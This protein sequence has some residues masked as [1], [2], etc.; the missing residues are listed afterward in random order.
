MQNIEN[1]GRFMDAESVEKYNKERM[2]AA[3]EKA[4]LDQEANPTTEELLKKIL[5]AL[6]EKN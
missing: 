2:A 3:E 4:R 5:T 6:Q 1:T